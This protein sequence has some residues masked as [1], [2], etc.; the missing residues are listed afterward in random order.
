MFCH[1]PGALIR[2]I[3]PHGVMT[4]EIPDWLVRPSELARA[5]GCARVG[6]VPCECTL[7][8]RG[9]RRLGKIPTVCRRRAV[10]RGCVHPVL[11]QRA[12]KMAK[13]P[14][15]PSTRPADA[16]FQC[17]TQKAV[18]AHDETAPCCDEKPH[19]VWNRA[20][21]RADLVSTSRWRARWLQSAPGW[22]QLRS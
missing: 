9:A 3:Q 19:A 16:S 8:P 21:S 7:R 17:S 2:H 12:V 22:R 6:V 4:R 14:R 18:A 10:R 15:R 13:P 5:R 1:A 20:A 11:I